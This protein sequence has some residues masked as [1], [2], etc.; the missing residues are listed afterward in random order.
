ML[1]PIAQNRKDRQY[2]GDPYGNGRFDLLKQKRQQ[3][4]KD[5]HEK[6]SPP[7]LP[8]RE[9]ISRTEKNKNKDRYRLLTRV[10]RRTDSP[11]RALTRGPAQPDQYLSYPE[12]ITNIAK[13]N[14]LEKREASEF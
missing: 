4:R 12:H 1:V 2:E 6:I 11:W 8:D 10:R 3:N 9:Q 14:R 7:R 13:P 5:N